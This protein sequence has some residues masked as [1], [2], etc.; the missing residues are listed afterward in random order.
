MWDGMSEGVHESISQ[1]LKR[2][3]EPDPGLERRGSG[4]VQEK[5]RKERKRERKTPKKGRERRT[6]T[7]WRMRAS[8]PLPLECKSSALPFELIP[9]GAAP[10]RYKHFANK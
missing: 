4:E 2:P 10:E 8:I 9:P 7:F 5:R 1:N 3:E 6:K